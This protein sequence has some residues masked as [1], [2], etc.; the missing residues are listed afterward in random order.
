MCKTRHSEEQVIR[1]LQE[2]ESGRTVSHV[3]R[4]YPIANGTYYAWRAS[5]GGMDLRRGPMVD[6]QNAP[7]FDRRVDLVARLG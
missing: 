5:C 3:C 1:V 4:E 7:T 6:L 2:V